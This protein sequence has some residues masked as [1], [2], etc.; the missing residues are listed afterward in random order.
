M[1]IDDVRHGAQFMHRLERAIA[2]DAIFPSHEKQNRC[3]DKNHRT[4]A[5]IK[6]LDEIGVIIHLE[7]MNVTNQ[8]DDDDDHARC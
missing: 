6:C 3:A 8:A 1:H 4:D 7:L 5:R 2:L